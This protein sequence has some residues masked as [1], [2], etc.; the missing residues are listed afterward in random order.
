MTLLEI[1]IVVAIIGIIIAAGIGTFGGVFNNA[2]DQ[3]ARMKINGMTTL[4]ESYRTAAGTYPS[5][6]QGLK[7]LVT[8]PTSAPKPKRWR[9]QMTS[10]PLDPWGSEYVYKYPGTK[11]PKTYEI[12][13][14]GED[15]QL[16]T[17]DDIS[18]Q[19]ER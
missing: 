18:S 1:V 6:S 13:S 19:D 7:A 14:I 17:S 8:E 3:A 10:L 12:L 16:G 9:Q 11:D 4:L 2:N 15:K 5:E